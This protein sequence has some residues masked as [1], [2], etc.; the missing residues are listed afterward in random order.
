MKNLART[1]VLLF[2]ALSLA[3][4][5]LFA[6][7]LSVS[8]QAGYPVGRPASQVAYGNG[9]YLLLTTYLYNQFFTSTT[10]TSWNAAD[11][12][13][14]AP[15]Q[16]NFMVFG[17]GLFVVVGNDGIIQTSADGIAWTSRTSGTAN[18]LYKVYFLNNTF[19]AIGN[20][21]TLLTSPD[22]INWSSITFSVGGILGLLSVVG[23]W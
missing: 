8:V 17:A 2:C 11:A 5:G 9:K 13:G 23:L 10:G 6:Q 3:V 1:C 16:L 19:F 4:S 14:L 7:S 20:N 12:T 15:G 22:G 21:R 18:D